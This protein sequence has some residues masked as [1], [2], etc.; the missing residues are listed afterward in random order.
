M[1]FSRYST[2]AIYPVIVG[3]VSR[4]RAVYVYVPITSLTLLPCVTPLECR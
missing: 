2:L 3:E 4:R 1:L